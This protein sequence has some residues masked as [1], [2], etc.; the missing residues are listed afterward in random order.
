MALKPEKNCIKTC[1]WGRVAWL[2][3]L[4]RI[5]VNLEHQTESEKELALAS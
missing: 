5:L 2:Q 4:E 3:K 1:I